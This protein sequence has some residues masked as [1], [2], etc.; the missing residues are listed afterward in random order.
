MSKEY[1]KLILD[2]FFSLDDDDISDRSIDL[3]NDIRAKLTKDLA[4]GNIK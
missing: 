4:K 1:L 2:L 3:M